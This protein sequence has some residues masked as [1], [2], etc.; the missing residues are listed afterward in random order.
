MFALLCLSAS[1]AVAHAADPLTLCKAGEVCWVDRSGGTAFTELRFRAQGGEK[2]VTVDPG[3]TTFA[4]AE[5]VRASGILPSDW[6]CVQARQRAADGTLSPW[7]IS[8]KEGVCNLTAKVLPPEPV[9]PPPPVV[10]PP[11]APVP[12]PI[13]PPPLP[14]PAPVELFGNVRNSDGVLSFDFAP[15][16]CK[17]GVQQTTSALKDGRRTITLTCRK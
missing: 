15:A 9:T 10:P 7:Y 6:L 11:P 4:F 1:G 8:D 2:V 13:V 16:D 3:V 17:R 5:I 14:P 12:P